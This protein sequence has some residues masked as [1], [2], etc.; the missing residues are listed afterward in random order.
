MIGLNYFLQEAGIDLGRARLVRHQTRAAPGRSPHDLWMATDGRFEMYQRI[1]GKE[2]FRSADWIIAFGATPLDETLFVGVYRVRGVG[3]VPPDTIDPCGGHDVTGLFLYDLELNDALR[4]YA[5]RIV[6]DWGTG[7]RSWVQRPDRQDKP[8]TEIRRTAI[9][10]P[11]PGFSSFSWP[12]RQLSSVPPSWRGALSAVS[13]RLSAR[14]PIDRQAVRR[15]GVWHRRVLDALGKL[16]P[17]GARWERGDE[18]RSREQ[19]S[20]LDPGVC[21]VLPGL[22]RGYPDGSAMEG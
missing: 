11:F 19:F 8:I 20:S 18:A 4:E 3:T 2:R 16:F 10:P 15:I 17:H 5:G 21:L 12:I 7:F 6:V 13:R 22:R 1:Q 14:V 9:E